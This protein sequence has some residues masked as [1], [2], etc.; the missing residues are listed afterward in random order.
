MDRSWVHG[1]RTLH[2]HVLE[3][4]FRVI[5][6]RTRSNKLACHKGCWSSGAKHLFSAS[7]KQD[8]NVRSQSPCVSLRSSGLCP[9]SMRATSRQEPSRRVAESQKRVA[10]SFRSFQHKFL[11]KTDSF[12]AK[13]IVVM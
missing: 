9:G 13:V 6:R 2:G 4:V 3:Q 11:C 12:I 10:S 8:I 5:R 7:L 1:C